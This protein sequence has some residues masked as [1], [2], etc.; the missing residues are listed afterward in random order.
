MSIYFIHLI[1]R[2]EDGAMRYHKRT[3]KVPNLHALSEINE[4]TRGFYK[5]T[6]EHL[7]SAVRREV[8]P[9]E[10]IRFPFSLSLSLSLFPPYTNLL[11][12]RD[13]AC[14]TVHPLCIALGV[15]RPPNCAPSSRSLE[16]RMGVGDDSNVSKSPLPLSRIRATTPRYPGSRVSWDRN[17]ETVSPGKTC[18]A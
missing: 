13:I 16:S 7:F 17:R 18:S 14:F 6:L 9:N 10:L 11:A 3:S 15:Q 4:S 5:I 2:D 1:V 8:L 12:E